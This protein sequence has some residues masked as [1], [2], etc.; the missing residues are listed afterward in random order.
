MKN[1]IFASVLTAM[2]VIASHAAAT[3][4]SIEQTGDKPSISWVANAPANMTAIVKNKL[5]LDTYAQEADGKDMHAL[6]SAV[7]TCFGSE[8]NP[9]KSQRISVATVPKPCPASAAATG[10]DDNKACA[11]DFEVTIKPY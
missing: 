2:T 3:T 8:G 4:C 6:P 9:I 10:S 11:P 7:L 1:L 5:L